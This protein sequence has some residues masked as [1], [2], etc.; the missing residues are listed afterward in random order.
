M[1][2]TLY[3]RVCVPAFLIWKKWKSKLLLWH[4]LQCQIG[5][6]A[7]WGISWWWILS[8]FFHHHS[9]SSCQHSSIHNM[10]H[11]V[12]SAALHSTSLCSSSLSSLFSTST[13]PLICFWLFFWG[14]SVFPVLNLTPPCCS[15]FQPKYLGAVKMARTF[16]FL[17]TVM[18]VYT[19]PIRAH[20]HRLAS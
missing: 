5:Q 10:P 2:W 15:L 20:I 18:G 8:L 6:L 19:T 7:L 14:P 16:F 3:V 11:S 4:Y 13:Y 17:L 9:L 12:L 1:I